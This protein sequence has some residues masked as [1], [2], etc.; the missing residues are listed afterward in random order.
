MA[1]QAVN[2]D[3][4]P[5]NLDKGHDCGFNCNRNLNNGKPLSVVF[6]FLDISLYGG[7]LG[8]ALKERSVY[9]HLK[10]QAW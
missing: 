4:S 8:L 1:G 5:I 9:Q 2:L 3:L 7:S 10:Y 6:L